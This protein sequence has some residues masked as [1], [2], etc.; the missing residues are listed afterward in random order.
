MCDATEGLLRNAPLAAASLTLATHTAVAHFARVLACAARLKVKVTVA[1]PLVRQTLPVLRA[2]VRLAGGALLLHHSALMEAL[3]ACH[4]WALAECAPAVAALCEFYCSDYVPIVPVGHLE[5]PLFSAV[6]VARAGAGNVTPLVSLVQERPGLWAAMAPSTRSAV[7][8]SLC[9][10]LVGGDAASV[11]PAC[12]LLQS[13]AAPQG[14]R[15][16]LLLREVM[17]R[18]CAP[19]SC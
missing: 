2:F 13:S 3:L 17:A 15:A 19:V 9:A 1:W 16:L 5:G 6:V 8:A 14:G 11:A 12:A 10:L 4:G 7:E 18:V